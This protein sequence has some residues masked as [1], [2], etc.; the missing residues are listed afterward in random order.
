M[1][2]LSNKSKHSNENP[3]NAQR[4]MHETPFVSVIITAFNR[5]QFLPIAIESVACQTLDRSKYE[6]IVVKNFLDEEIDSKLDKL[7]SKVI[8]MANENMGIYL[9]TAIENCVGSV[10]VFLDD[11][12]AF[13][14]NR[15]QIIYDLFKKHMQIGYFHNDRIVVNEYGEQLRDDEAFRY[16]ETEN[17]Q[18]IGSFLVKASPLTKVSVNRLYLVHAFNYKSSLALRKSVLVPFLPYLSLINR[19][20]DYFMFYSALTSGCALAMDTRK[21]TKYRLHSSNISSFRYKSRSP[22]LQQSYINHVQE[23][24]KSLNV[25]LV[26]LYQKNPD[27]MVTKMALHDLWT[28]K[29]DL[30]AIDPNC[31]R[32]KRLFD[33]SK[34]LMVGFRASFYY[35]NKVLLRTLISLF[36]PRFTRRWFLAQKVYRQ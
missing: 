27:K 14:K 6:M 15:L 3:K 25:I 35:Q 11:D 5:K 31:P 22:N 26:M 7:G 33:L 12:D 23:G 29:V 36:F 28:L 17:I 19:S 9:V 18:R 24:I 32:S 20:P 13:E 30:D 1:A 4:V 16:A 10:L 21:L 2:S 8:L 34:Y